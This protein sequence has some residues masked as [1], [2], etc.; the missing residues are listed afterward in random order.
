MLFAHVCLSICLTVWLS[1][2]L[3]VW[4]SGCPSGCPSVWLSGWLVSLHLSVCLL[5]CSFLLLQ[6]N[7]GSGQEGPTKFDLNVVPAWIQGYTGKGVVVSVVDEGCP[8]AC[9]VTFLSVCKAI[10]PFL[11]MYR[12]T[13]CVECHTI[14]DI[15][16]LAVPFPGYSCIVAW[17]PGDGT[18][19]LG[20]GSVLVSFP[21]LLYGPKNVTN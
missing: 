19:L 14:F 17:E 18:Q 21:G 12:R 10:D 7:G 9:P 8:S 11:P 6:F 16:S 15:M 13:S 4:L 3:A 2:C 20:H 5:A 1:V